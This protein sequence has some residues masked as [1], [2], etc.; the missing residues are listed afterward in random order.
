MVVRRYEKPFI[1]MRRLAR[2]TPGNPTV[3]GGAPMTVCLDVGVDG[4]DQTA[5]EDLDG[6]MADQGFSVVGDGSTAGA[7][8]FIITSPDG[9]EWKIIV[10]DDGVISTS[11][12]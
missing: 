2:C 4:S 5:I 3:V 9:V 12:V 6:G 8:A 11:A 10:D 1:D 7:P